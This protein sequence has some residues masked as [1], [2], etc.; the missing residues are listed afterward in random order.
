VRRPTRNGNGFYYLRLGVIAKA[1][2]PGLEGTVSKRAGSYRGH[3]SKRGQPID[4]W[5][6][7]RRRQADEAQWNGGFRAHS[8]PSKC[9]RRKRAIRPI[10]ASKAAICNG[11]ITSIP[12]LVLGH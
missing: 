2:D 6:V 8:G 10:E 12:D 5:S 4:A 3:E 1:C 7:M 11:R 9:D